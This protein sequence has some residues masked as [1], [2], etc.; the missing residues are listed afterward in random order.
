MKTIF[1]IARK[2]LR[3]NI[4]S[5]RFLICMAVCLLFVP[6]T[7]ITGTDNY[8]QQT[9]IYQKLEQEAEENLHSQHVWSMIRPV[10]LK[11]PEPLN[12]FSQGINTNIGIKNTVALGDYPNFPAISGYTQGYYNNPLLNAFSFTDFSGILGIVVSLLAFS[13]AY[14]AFTQ[15]KEEGMLQMIF[16]EPVRRKTFLLGKITGIFLTLAPIVLCC[17]LIAVGYLIYEG[18][19]LQKTEWNGI[20]LLF[21]LS[22]CYLFLFIL[23]GTYISSLF[24]RSQSSLI[25]CF[26]CWISVIF[27]IPPTASYLSHIFVP[28][29]DYTNIADE[30]Q[31]LDDEFNKRNLYIN[32]SLSRKIDEKNI[33]SAIYD[34]GKVDIWGIS[35]EYIKVIQQR[36]G[37]TNRLRLE[38]ADRKWEIKRKYLESMVTQQKIKQGISHLSPMQVYTDAT[39]TICRT[40]ADYC[41]EYMA[42]ERAYRKQV[43]DFFLQ[44]HLFDSLSYFT[45]QKKED[46]KTYAGLFAYFDTNFKDIDK[47]SQDSLL[48]ILENRP[49]LNADAMPRFR[50]SPPTVGRQWKQTLPVFEGFILLSILFLYLLMRSS[51]NY[52]IR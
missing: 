47:E 27:I 15:E 36:N 33:Y 20:F 41:L 50:Q 4:R 5:V 43:V 14:N 39:Q 45:T 42:E 12:I 11:Q 48:H 44:N 46:W 7:V 34:D 23:I 17:Y 32:D 21:I 26:L 18:I 52:D 16:A 35:D 49:K 30:L 13:F 31:K 19:P 38:Q 51:A 8:L 2:D 9:E 6:F 22:L 29:R 25:V 37:I 3:L 1:L 10:M 40:S 28:L 24:H